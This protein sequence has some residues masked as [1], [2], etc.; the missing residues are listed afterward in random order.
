LYELRQD[1][2]DTSVA[3]QLARISPVA[4]QHIN[5]HGRYEFAKIPQSIDPEALVMEL[6]A[7]P[8]PPLDSSD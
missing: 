7:R 6:A 4:W 2:G 1:Q 8:L 5:F 3:Q